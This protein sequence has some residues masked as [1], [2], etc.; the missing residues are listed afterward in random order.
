M[1]TIQYSAR[2]RRLSVHKLFTFCIRR[3]LVSRACDWPDDSVICRVTKFRLPLKL[4]LLRGS[5]PKSTRANPKQCT[6]SA[7]AFIQIGWL[8]RSYSRT[9]EHRQIAPKSESN[10]RR[11]SSFQPNNYNATTNVVWVCLLNSVVVHNFPVFFN[12]LLVIFNTTPMSICSS[13]T[14][15]S[16]VAEKPRDAAKNLTKECS[17]DHRCIHGIKPG[18]P[19]RTI[20]KT[21]I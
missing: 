16:A 1:P 8:W 13:T 19:L 11:K 9:R 5:H 15:C 10:I 20:L 3:Y 21:I 17:R 2:S 12:V 18:S 6:Q 7:P 4:S 14:I